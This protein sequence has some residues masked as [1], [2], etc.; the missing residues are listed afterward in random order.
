MA[1]KEKAKKEEKVDVAAETKDGEV[2]C[3]AN[4]LKISPQKLMRIANVVRFQSVSVAL[5]TLKLM[6]HDGAELLYKAVHSAMSNAVNNNKLDAEKLYISTL[7]VNKGVFSKRF[8]AR[9]R[10]RSATIERKSS[11][12]IVGVKEKVGS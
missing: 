4:Y 10:G 8:R 11:K 2:F 12:L 3:K 9:A 7:L 1:T 6:P 5:Q